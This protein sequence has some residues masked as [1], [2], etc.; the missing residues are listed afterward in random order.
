M[1]TKNELLSYK[2]WWRKRSLGGPCWLVNENIYRSSNKYANKMF[3][4]TKN[5]KYMKLCG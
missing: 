1:K 4:R 3:Y 2:R 5:L